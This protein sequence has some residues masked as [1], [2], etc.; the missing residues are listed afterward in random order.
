MS[1]LSSVAFYVTRGQETTVVFL[2]YGCKIPE[3]ADNLAGLATLI[4]QATGIEPLLSRG[5]Q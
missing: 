2:Y 1:D 5:Q 4:D 3:I